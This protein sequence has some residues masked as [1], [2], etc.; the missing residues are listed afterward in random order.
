MVDPVSIEETF[1]FKER[2]HEFADELE[3]NT[4]HEWTEDSNSLYLKDSYNDEQLKK[5]AANLPHLKKICAFPFYTMAIHVNGDVSVCCVD[6]NK[7][8]TVGNIHQET[9]SEIWNGKAL[10]KFRE[11]HLSDRRKEIEGCK[12]CSYFQSNCRENIDKDSEMV[13]R[14]IRS[15]RV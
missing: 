10:N 12:N 13:L 14:K 8:A 7:K 5:I 6:W 11:L 3:I 4:P 1:A 2:Y 15:L 9:L